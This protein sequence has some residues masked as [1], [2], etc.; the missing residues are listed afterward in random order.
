MDFDADLNS[1]SK[2]NFR[3]VNELL[4]RSLTA[5][6]VT[7]CP[8]YFGNLLQR[9]HVLYWIA[10]QYLQNSTE[11]KTKQRCLQFSEYS[12]NIPI[13]LKNVLNLTFD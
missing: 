8:W 7:K 9:I 12:I 2:Q 11:I 6:I 10:E 1:I 4:P 3:A 13:L 5:Q